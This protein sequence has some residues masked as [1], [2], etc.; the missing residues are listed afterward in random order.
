[1]L[2]DQ[3]VLHFWDADR[4]AGPWFAKTVNGDDGYMWDA[5]LLY[6]P[7]ANWDQAPAPLIGSGGTIIDTGPQ[8]RD[9]LAPL[10]K[11]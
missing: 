5:Y 9:E 3:R 2:P 7:N 11:P 10:I 6:G 1:V 4:F 8:L